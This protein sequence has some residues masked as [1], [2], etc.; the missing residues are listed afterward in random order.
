MDL[1]GPATSLFCN[2]DRGNDT[3]LAKKLF[4]SKKY[5]ILGSRQFIQKIPVTTSADGI[6]LLNN[7]TLAEIE[8]H[9]ER[10]EHQE[11]RNSGMRQK[12]EKHE[13]YERMKQGP[14]ENMTV[15]V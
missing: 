4:L 12:R 15:A 13:K 8:G 9:R 6:L 5:I 1:A 10:L 14:A 3:K 2:L 11:T 7:E